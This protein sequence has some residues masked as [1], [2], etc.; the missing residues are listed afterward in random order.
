MRAP[1]LQV[2]EHGDLDRAVQVESEVVA[3]REVD[4]P[5][6]LDPHPATLQLGDDRVG[7]RVRRLEAS[8]LRAHLCPK[9]SAAARTRSLHPAG[10]PWLPELFP[11]LLLYHINTHQ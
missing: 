10:L 1:A 5:T 8:Y 4:E 9:V 6:I 3:G 2:P 7:H 11:F